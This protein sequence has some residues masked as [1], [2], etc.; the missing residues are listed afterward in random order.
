MFKPLKQRYPDSVLDIHTSTQYGEVFDNNPYPTNVFKHQSQDK[1]SSLHLGVTLPELLK[2][3]NYDIIFNPHPM[4]NSS[5]W[6]S[7]QHPE[8]GENLIFAWVHALEEKQIP[9]EAPLETILRLTEGEVHKI[10]NLLAGLTG[11]RRNIIMEIHGESGQTFWDHNWTLRIGE[12]LLSNKNTNLFLSH[13]DLRGDVLELQRRFP[14]QAHWVG[15]LTIRECAELFNHCNY[16]F[17]ISS[18]L[19][20]ACNTNWCRKDVGWF[21][22]VNSLSCSSAA[23]RKEG[24]TF[25]HD[26]NIDNFVNHLR[27]KGV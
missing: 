12:H 27:E 24:K 10:T 1:N 20:N 22:V 18:G 17:S 15:N 6:C 5:K 26:N 4:F 21:E 25:W 19:S 2:E 13:R 14:G 9:Y 16:F 7:C 8:W 3:S 23:I 11:G